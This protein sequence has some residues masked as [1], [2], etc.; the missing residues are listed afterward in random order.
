MNHWHKYIATASGYMI[1]HKTPLLYK[2]KIKTYV[3]DRYI[4]R[5]MLIGEKISILTLSTVYSPILMPFWV[6]N[7]LN[8]LEICC[9]KHQFKD[10]G[11]KQCDEYMDF[12][13]A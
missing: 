6:I 4:K 10:Y 2:A 9:K 11:F 5:D 1:L 3:D 12:V 13:L 8:K 7:D